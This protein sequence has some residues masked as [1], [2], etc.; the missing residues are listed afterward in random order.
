MP[1]NWPQ[2]IC[3]WWPK[4]V[5]DEGR[6]KMKTSLFNCHLRHAQGMD[7]LLAWSWCA[8]TLIHVLFIPVWR[9]LAVFLRFK[10]LYYVFIGAA[11][12]PRPSLHTQRVLLHSLVISFREL[13]YILNPGMPVCTCVN[14]CNHCVQLSYNSMPTQ[15]RALIHCLIVQVLFFH[16][17][18]WL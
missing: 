11:P 5:Q 16:V 3:L 18:G 14:E 4:Y 10:L 12:L 2:A 6:R 7:P 1:E 8:T 17:F 15:L 9:H 13:H